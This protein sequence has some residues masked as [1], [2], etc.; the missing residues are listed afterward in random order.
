MP[1]GVR[2]FSA[3]LFVPKAVC[4]IMFAASSSHAAALHVLK[5]LRGTSLSLDDKGS[6]LQ[7]LFLEYS[8]RRIELMHF[9]HDR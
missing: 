9:S 5:E 7:Q 2:A 4:S 6:E 3:K 8:H 1:R